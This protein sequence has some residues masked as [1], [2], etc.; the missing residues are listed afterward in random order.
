M[1]FRLP[2]GSHWCEQKYLLFDKNRRFIMQKIETFL[3]KVFI[4]AVKGI[5]FPFALL[6]NGVIWIITECKKLVSAF[7][8]RNTMGG[9]MKKKNNSG[10]LLQWGCSLA[11]GVAV[12]AILTLALW[13]LFALIAWVRGISSTVE[14]ARESSA[15]T[16]V[17]YETPTPTSSPVPTWTPTPFSTPE[18]VFMKITNSHCYTSGVVIH[19]PAPPVDS[20][21]G[22]TRDG[23][24][25]P[26]GTDAL[27]SCSV[28]VPVAG[29]YQLTIRTDNHQ[30]QPSDTQMTIMVNG[31]DK[32][33]PTMNRDAS[34]VEVR[35][36]QGSNVI[37]MKGENGY[38]SGDETCKN[39]NHTETCLFIW[40]I[41]L[42][43]LGQ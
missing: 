32:V 28:T 10:C 1:N 31:I 20:S 12:V 42:S 3:R 35:L 41:Q 8:N 30:G 15:A 17:V 40:G 29:T 25:L 11:G 2:A 38:S 43:Y 5:V 18:P 27:L 33:V 22:G 39:A 14:E 34:S 36:N 23:V 9:M 37:V 19:N 4:G 6:C 13:G 7:K 24:Y 26:E 16:A 21:N